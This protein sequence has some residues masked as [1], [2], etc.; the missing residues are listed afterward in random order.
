MTTVSITILLILANVL[1]A[2][3][4]YP[5]AARLWRTGDVDGVSASW[6]GVSVSMNLWWLAYGLTTGLWGLVPVS[7]IAALLY[8]SMIV[9]YVRV[10]G[11]RSS[12]GLLLGAFG[13]G[14]APLPFLI[15][16]GW[17]HAGLA[18]GLC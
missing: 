9:T 15:V 13:F 8:V 6:L 12:P 14:L 4:A 17:V 11:R 7:G 5:Q 2:T 16:G 3:M 1:G 18:I 10:I